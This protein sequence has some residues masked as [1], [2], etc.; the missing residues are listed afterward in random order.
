LIQAAYRRGGFETR[1]VSGGPK[2][3]D[4]DRFDIDATVDGSLSLA[5][6][7]LPDGKGSAGLAYLMLRTLLAE[8]FKLVLHTETQQLPIYALTMVRRDN[9]LGP[10]LHKSDVDCDAVLAEIARTGHPAPPKAPGQMPPCSTQD[11][12]GHIAANAISMSQLAEMLSG[13]AERETHDQTNLRGTFDLTLDWTP[14]TLPRA[15]GT[16]P[17]QP[18]TA[19]GVKID[20]NGPPLVT[21]LQEQLGLKLESTKGPVDVLVIDHVERPTPD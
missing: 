20:P 5:A 15:V 21:A 9:S 13:F 16:S 6:L 8:R 14:D 18:T 7:Y 3:I 19:N 17:D 2:W 11:R 1:Q 10:Q 4:S 12:P